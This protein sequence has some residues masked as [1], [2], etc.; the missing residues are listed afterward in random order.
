LAA[1]GLDS[2]PAPTDPDALAFFV[3]AAATL[4]LLVGPQEVMAKFADVGDADHQEDMVSRLWR[5]ESAHTAAVLEAVGE[6]HGDKR[7]RKAARKS[8]F[9]LRSAG[10]GRPRG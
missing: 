9:R 8:L 5:V 3:D 4:L 7:L 10:C 6:H 1:H 2:A